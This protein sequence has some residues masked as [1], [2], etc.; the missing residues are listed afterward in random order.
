MASGLKNYLSFF[1]KNNTFR[2]FFYFLLI[3]ASLWFLSRLSDTYSYKINLPVRYMDTQGTPL[4]SSFNRD[5][6]YVEIEASG[7]RILGIKLQ[8]P[9]FY[10]HINPKKSP[11]W[12]PPKKFS[13]IRKLLGK[14]VKIIQIKP[15]KISINHKEI[16]QKSLPVIPVIDIEFREG[17]KNTSPPVLFPPKITVYGKKEVLDS[18]KKI[19]TLPVHLTDVHSDI[20]KN[21][22]LELPNGIK[23]GQSSVSLKIPVD[24][25][26]EDEKILPV[27]LPKNFTNNDY[28]ILPKTARL[29]FSFFKKDFT[30]L[31]NKEL[32]L[33][34]NPEDLKKGKRKAKIYLARKPKEI[35][36]YKIIPQEATILMKNE[37]NN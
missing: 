26:V 6:L 5:T 25:I 22:K 8:K 18:M 13:S 11:V 17:Y 35:L 4:P 27:S 29:I 1:I 32:K 12:Y 24:Q 37:K 23:A 2:N 9:I 31:Q 33:T 14:E 28:L 3:S 34:V 7:F 36:N 20:E 30:S 10:Y 19:N 16:T 21:I 15:D